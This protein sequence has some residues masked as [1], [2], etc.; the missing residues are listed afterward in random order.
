MYLL[1]KARNWRF[2]GEFGSFWMIWVIWGL[3][4][5]KRSASHRCVAPLSKCSACVKLHREMLPSAHRQLKNTAPSSEAQCHSIFS[6]NAMTHLYLP[7]NSWNR[8]LALLLALWTSTL[9]QWND[10]YKDGFILSLFDFFW[11]KPTFITSICFFQYS[12]FLC[13]VSLLW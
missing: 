4:G 9:T 5:S 1:V 7:N 13:L 10:K 12:F 6:R 2:W 11:W 3:A 8:S